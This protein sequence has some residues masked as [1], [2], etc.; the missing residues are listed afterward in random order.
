MT[1][2]QIEVQKGP[3]TQNLKVLAESV[4]K[5]INE[6]EAQASQEEHEAQEL[7][8]KLFEAQI[9][10]ERKEAAETKGRQAKEGI[11]GT[12]GE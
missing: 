12:L 10:Q 9:T 3:E 6:A 1:G 8:N 2:K 11:E 5:K 7:Q 4:N